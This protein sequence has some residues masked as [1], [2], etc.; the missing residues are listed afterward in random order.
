LAISILKLYIQNIINNYFY[1]I[2]ILFFLW[3][4]SQYIIFDFYYFKPNLID[5]SIF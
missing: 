3:I 2:Q 1:N 5:F 4:N